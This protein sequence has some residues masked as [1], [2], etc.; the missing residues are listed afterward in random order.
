MTT[1]VRPHRFS[2]LVRVPSSKSH[3][4]RCLLI[5]AMADGI[6]EILNP[7]D[8]LDTRSCVSVCRALGAEISEHVALDEKGEKLVSWKVKGH[9]P[10]FDGSSSSEIKLC[11]VGNSGTTLFLALAMAALGTSPV[12][13][14][15]DEQ[16]QRRGAGPL[17]LALT[18]LGAYVESGP[19]G[20]VPIS[21]RGPFKGGRV[22]LP[23]PTSQYLSALLLAAPMA[24]AGVVTEIDVPLLNEKPYI[25]MTLSYLDSQNIPFEA[26]P[27]FSYFKIPG[28]SAWKPL[29]GQVPGDFSSAAYPAAAAAITGASVTL[30]GLD[31]DDSQGDKVFFDFLQNMGCIVSWELIPGQRVSLGQFTSDGLEAI[32]VNSVEINYGEYLL[33]VSRSGPLMGGEFD[34]NGTPDLLPVM[35]AVASYAK[36]DTAL[37]N[38]AHA[39]IKETDRLSV[40]TQELRKLVEITERP[41]GLVIH[42]C[43]GIPLPKGENLK[44]ESR[45]DHRV[46]M[47]LAVAALGCPLPVEISGAESAELSYPGF[48]G[49]IGADFVY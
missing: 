38:V 35:A 42:G 12:K 31:P 21:V 29:D 32:G 47:A 18:G 17:L 34:L 22:V 36:G 45:G 6:S 2:G 39:R 30:L 48:L 41:D 24:P 28:G 1:L 15:G 5:A 20:N 4:I 8:C 19:N 40:I 25:E 37:V 27:D 33:N 13:F 43:G 9:G 26:A 46:F 23:C 14:E 44:L 3:T 10:F 49:L 7:L 11:N 16:T